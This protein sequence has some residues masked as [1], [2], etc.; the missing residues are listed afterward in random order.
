MFIFDSESNE[1][2]NSASPSLITDKTRDKHRTVGSVDIPNMNMA[3]ST[4]FLFQ[5]HEAV[6]EKAESVH[7]VTLGPLV[8]LCLFNSGLLPSPKMPQLS[9]SAL[10][11]GPRGVTSPA[12]IR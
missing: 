6:P 2:D 7:T 11:L 3:S 5:Q 8:T 1:S 4:V 10:R 9:L 12:R